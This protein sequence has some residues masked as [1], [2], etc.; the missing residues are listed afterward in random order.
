MGEF[1]IGECAKGDG[2]ESVFMVLKHA[3]LCHVPHGCRYCCV[4]RKSVGYVE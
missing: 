3:R 4:Q 1:Y 2:H